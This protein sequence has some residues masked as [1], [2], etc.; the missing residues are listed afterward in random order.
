V[1]EIT[2]RQMLPH[3]E[4]LAERLDDWLGG[5]LSRSQYIRSAPS[6]DTGVRVHRDGSMTAPEL[7]ALA[8]EIC[9][10][11]GVTLVPVGERYFRAVNSATFCTEVG[12]EAAKRCTAE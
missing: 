8:T 7:L 4:S 11:N 3:T 9:A 12:S 10:T 5:K 2:G 6:P 1:V